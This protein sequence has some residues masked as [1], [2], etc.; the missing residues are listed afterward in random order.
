MA[1]QDAPDLRA[2]GRLRPVGAVALL[3]QRRR[4]SAATRCRAAP[5]PSRRRPATR[6]Q[7]RS[8]V[9]PNATIPSQSYFDLTL[10]ARIGDHYNFRL[11]VNNIFDREPPIIGANGGNTVINACPAWSASATPSRRSTTRWAATSSP[12]SRSTSK[13][14]GHH[15]LTAGLRARRFLLRR[16]TALESMAGGPDEPEPQAAAPPALRG[17]GRCGGRA[18]ATRPRR[19]ALLEQATAAD[20]ERGETWLKLAAMC[21]AQGD[22]AAALAA[23][24]GALRI[25]PLGFVPLLLK[26]NLLEQ[27]GRAAEAGET[28]GYALAQA[29]APVPPHLEAMVAHAGA[30]HDAHVA[31]RRRAAGRRRRAGA[32]LTRGRAAPAR[33]LPEQRPAPTAALS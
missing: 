32:D 33:P 29:P 19:A 10:T 31:A 24:S 5:P 4:R 26:A 17:R 15:Q 14:A 16:A 1:A 12:A 3:L 13:T 23:V 22:L 6:S 11:G 28:Y 9:R 21:R 7:R 20:P 27:M 25:D 2:S 30:R 18:A 8:A